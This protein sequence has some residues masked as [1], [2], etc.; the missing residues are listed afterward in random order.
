MSK[1]ISMWA[2][3][4]VDGNPDV[5]SPCQVTVT[6]PTISNVHLRIYSIRY[7]PGVEPFVYAEN[8]SMNGFE[9]L[10]QRGTAWD[11]FPVSKGKAVLLSGGDKIRLCNQTIFLF[12][13]R[14]RASQL[15][16]WTQHQ[17][18]E[19]PDCRQVL[20]KAAFDNLYAMTDRKLGSG[21]SGRVFM[22]IDCVWRRQMACKVV[23]FKR[24]HDNSDRG[25]TDNAVWPRLPRNPSQQAR[26]WREVDILKDLT[27]P[28]VITVDRVFYTDFNIYIIEELITGGDLMSFI[29]RHSWRVDPDEACLIVYQILKAVGYLHQNG[30]THRDLK[31]ENVLLSTTTAGARVVVTDFGGATKSIG[32]GTEKSRRMQTMTGT[33][34]YLAPEI[35]GKNRLVQQPGYTN[36]VDM[37]SIGCVTAAMLFGRSAFAMSQVSTGRQPSAATVINAA[38]KCDLRVLDD[39][40]VWGEI[41]TAAKD[42]IKRLLVLDEKGRLTAEESMAHRWFTQERRG[43]S[44][45]ERY[46]QAIVSWKPCGASWD[47][48]ENLD[49]FIE[50]RVA[51]KDIAGAININQASNY[52]TLQQAKCSTCEIQDDKSAYWTPLLYYQH[53]NGSFEEVNNGGMTVYYLG[54]GNNKDL[55]PFPP[56]F[57]M[58]SGS[59]NARSYNQNALIPGSQRPVADR[60]SFA[61][62]DGTSS[63]EQPGMVRTDCKHGLRAQI[64][65]QSCWNG[66]DLYKEDNSHVEYMTGIDNGDCPTTHRVPLVHMFFE[67]LYGVND[68]NK[69]DGGKFVFSQGDTTGYGFHGDFL[70]GWKADVLTSAIN[71]CAF[72]NDAGVEN[73]A[74]FKPSLDPNFA[75]TCPEAPSLLNEPV[76]G[77]IDKLPGCIT[78]T[79]GPQDATDAAYTCDAGQAA[80][81]GLLST[82]MNSTIGGVSSFAGAAATTLI[83][84]VSTATSSFASIGTS[85]AGNATPTT[86]TASTRATGNSRA[87]NNDDDDDTDSNNHNHNRRSFKGSP[88][89]GDGYNYDIPGSPAHGAPVV[90]G[91]P[92]ARR[93]MHRRSSH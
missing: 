61:C 16:T 78:L 19:D 58:V 15:L 31:P 45:A 28:N 20:E 86:S 77:V 64:H 65:F 49:R 22:V 84:K 52:D 10:H 25:S 24:C 79:P 50:G 92:V 73:C 56:G 30:I 88:V 23:Q 63:K 47:F 55:K 93:H 59:K 82:P 75:K 13:T 81:A 66:I 39:A 53:A 90:Y 72:T 42:F 68:I 33:A 41:D 26:L 14:L 51:E 11:A 2:A 46:D 91:S 62:L 12:E 1:K 74:P 7:D 71:Q 48:K 37:W 70:N 17:E 80:G 43:H 27:H 4:T 89:E 8:L 67:V 34:N 60:V 85:S 87:G 76:H 69:G 21:I 57:R 29:E 36:A 18:Q 3:L 44:T 32:Y 35:R 6:D 54:R 5:S 83:P 38:A 40:D 9:W